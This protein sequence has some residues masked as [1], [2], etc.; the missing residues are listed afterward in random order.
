M[1]LGVRP[2]HDQV[3]LRQRFDQEKYNGI[4]IR[5]E[6]FRLRT[7]EGDV[8]AVGP[9]K[10]RKGSDSERLPMDVKVGDRVIYAKYK[11]SNVDAAASKTVKED[12]LVVHEDDILAVYE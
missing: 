1:S 11:G 2:I 10:L 6:E 5:P 4:L 3:F 7:F 9:G 12:L 8:L